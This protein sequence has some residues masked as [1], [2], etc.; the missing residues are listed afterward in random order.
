MYIRSLGCA[1]CSSGCTSL[2]AATQCPPAN[3]A[4]DA[5]TL[6]PAAT[7]SCNW[8]WVLIALGL[9]LAFGSATQDRRV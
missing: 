5:A 8:T 7:Q 9:G 1:D 6:L 2:G 3:V 4:T